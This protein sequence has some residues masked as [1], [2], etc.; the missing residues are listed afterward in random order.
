MLLRIG[1]KL[2]ERA[3]EIRRR[4]EGL[5]S[6]R[7][8]PAQ[9]RSRMIDDVAACVTPAHQ[10]MSHTITRTLD[11]QGGEEGAIVACGGFTGGYALRQ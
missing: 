11:V 1:R 5:H 9:N 6:V 4:G 3:G 8:V 2:L 7:R 10:G